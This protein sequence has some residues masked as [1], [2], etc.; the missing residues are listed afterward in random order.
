MYAIRM[1]SRKT[2]ESITEAAD[3]TKRD[4]RGEEGNGGAKEGHTPKPPSKNVLTFPQ[5]SSSSQ[6]NCSA[7]AASSRSVGVGVSSR[8]WDERK[9]EKAAMLSYPILA[10]ICRA[11]AE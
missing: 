10:S 5:L 11:R 2:E 4:E 7:A 1:K 3:E 9:Q 8:K 6:N